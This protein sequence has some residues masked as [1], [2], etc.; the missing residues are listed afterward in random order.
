MDKAILID[1]FNKVIE[2][3]KYEYG[4]SYTQITE[5][6][7]TPEAPRPMFCTVNIDDS[8][9][10]YL[11]DEGLYRDTQAYF[12]WEGYHQ[13]LQGRGLILGVDYETGETVP[14]TITLEK[15]KEAVSFRGDK[16]RVMPQFEVRSFSDDEFNEFLQSL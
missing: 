14:P 1:P 12:Q 6:I 11:D 15:V 8:N 2:E 16:L 7:A 3:V 9:T 13:P 4:G 5:H 10:I